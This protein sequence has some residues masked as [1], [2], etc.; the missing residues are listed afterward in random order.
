[1]LLTVSLVTI[2]AGVAVQQVGPT[3]HSSAGHAATQQVAAALRLTRMRAIA[4]NARFRVMFDT[5]N[6][7]FTV[8]R[9]TSPGNF[10]VDEGPFEL[11]GAAAITE[12]TPSD[13]IF[14]S[15]GALTAPTTITIEA[16]HGGPHTITA[17]LLG[18]VTA[19]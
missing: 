3:L 2:T 18:R 14:D 6:A 1:M 17:N 16:P 13:P 4:Q 5:A 15:R 10:V 8:E 19:S 12:V 7:K 11:P 9:E